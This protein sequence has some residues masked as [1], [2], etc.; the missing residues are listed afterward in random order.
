MDS[1]GA[2]GTPGEVRTGA[3]ATGVTGPVR[4]YPLSRGA[5]LPPRPTCLWTLSV[6]ASLGD[7]SGLPRTVCR[8]QSSVEWSVGH[9]I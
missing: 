1:A 7:D 8:R 2:Q 3:G 5:H 9:S 4:Q 6:L